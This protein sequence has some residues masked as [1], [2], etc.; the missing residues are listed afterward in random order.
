MEE[1][2]YSYEFAMG[3][4]IKLEKYLEEKGYKSEPSGSL[5]RKR[6]DVGDIDFLVPVPFKFENKV[7]IPELLKDLGFII[8]FHI[9]GS[10]RLIHPELI[11]EFLVPERRRGREKPFPLPQLGLNAQSLRFLDFLIENS[12]KVKV[13]NLKL[14]LPHPAAFALHKLIVSSRRHKGEKRQ[15]DKAG[16]IQ[17]LTS[18]IAKGEEDTIKRLFNS[19]PKKP[20][21]MQ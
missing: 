17:I 12:M 8:D 5:R 15:K 3:E 1:K 18:L 10:I 7:D 21:W 19:M 11:I 6:K 9:K 13:N 16:A 4:Y 2:R 20:G 14:N